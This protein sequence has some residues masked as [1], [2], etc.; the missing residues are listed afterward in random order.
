MSPFFRS[1]IHPA[2]CRTWNW[3]TSRAR[4]S[5]G[6][7]L[8]LLFFRLLPLRH[9]WFFRWTHLNPLLVEN[10]CG[11]KLLIRWI[12]QT[13]TFK[14]VSAPLP[15]K[16]PQ[17]LERLKRRK[18]REKF[19]FHSEREEGQRD[20]TRES[21][22]LFLPSSFLSVHLSPLRWRETGANRQI[23]RDGSDLLPL[24]ENL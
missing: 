15:T 19:M 12:I 13:L 18:T 3:V 7:P 23:D 22:P 16:P 20:K 4:L 14:G 5:T 8:A 1:F 9:V 2:S 11:K 21:C 6:R 17:W 10:D 24:E